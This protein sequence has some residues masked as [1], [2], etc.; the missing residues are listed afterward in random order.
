[1]FYK[2]QAVHHHYLFHRSPVRSQSR[3]GFSVSIMSV[4]CPQAAKRSF[5]KV[6]LSIAALYSVRLTLTRD[7]P[8]EECIRAFKWVS[9]KAHP[10]KGGLLAHSQALNT[11]KDTWDK[12]RHK[13]TG[14]QGRATRSSSSLVAARGPRQERKKGLRVQSLGVL[15]TY[16]GVRDQT[17]WRRFVAHVESKRFWSWL[18][19]KLRSMDLADALQGRPVL[20]KMAYKDRVRRV[21]RT[22]KA[23]TTAKNCANSLRKVCR[24]VVKKK[25]AATGY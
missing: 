13:K 11:A 23:Q 24:E 2:S 12:A 17:Q 18:K 14:G 10:D 8:D 7:S 4:G 5:V 20:G 15:L 21:L 1:M 16:N 22:K 6:L 3:W 9:L 19:K 25:G